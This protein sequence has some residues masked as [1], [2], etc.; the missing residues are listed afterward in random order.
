M[1]KIIL[2]SL[3]LGALFAQN[4]YLVTDNTV[5]NGKVFAS[6]IDKQNKIFTYVQPL[7]GINTQ[8]LQPVFDNAKKDLCKKPIVQKLLSQGY[9]IEFIYMGKKKSVIMRFTTCE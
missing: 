1:K 9:Q 4:L 7:Q 3:T 6:F 2:T 5:K 8:K